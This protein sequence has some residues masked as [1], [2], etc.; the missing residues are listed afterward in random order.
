MAY[1]NVKKE[2]KQHGDLMQL[3]RNH[4]MQDEEDMADMD[5]FIGAEEGQSKK[6]GDYFNKPYM[7]SDEEFEESYPE[8]E[9]GYIDEYDDEEEPEED[10]E[11]PEEEAEVPKDKRKRMGIAVI[12]KR[13]SKPKNM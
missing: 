4:F 13:M 6:R 1:A 2:K 5:D 3:L 9:G 8:D 10:A 11:E 7:T 12:S